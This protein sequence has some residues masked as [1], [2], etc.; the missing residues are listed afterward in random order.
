MYMYNVKG[1]YLRY[2]LRGFREQGTKTFILG[3]QWNGPR[4]QK[5]TLMGTGA[6]GQ[7][8]GARNIGIKT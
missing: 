3:E 1:P 7:V 2:P 5:S 6:Q 8:W 4:E